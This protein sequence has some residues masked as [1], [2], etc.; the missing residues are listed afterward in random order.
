MEQ[1]NEDG[2][3]TIPLDLDDTTLLILMKEAHKSNMSFNQYI[4]RALEQYIIELE[5][6]CTHNKE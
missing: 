2:S 3:V 6:K 4:T 1:E 5:A